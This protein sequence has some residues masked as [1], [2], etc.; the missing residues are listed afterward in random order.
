MNDYA[1]CLQTIDG[2]YQDTA[3]R[4]R[5]FYPEFRRSWDAL[6]KKAAHSGVTYF[7]AGSPAAIS[8]PC[9]YGGLD[10][11]FHLDQSKMA[12]WY[13]QEVKRRKRVVFAPKRFKRSFSGKLSFHESVCHYDPALPEAAL[14]EKDRNILAAAFPGLPP[15]LYVVYGN[16]WVDRAV[17]P[18]HRSSV[19]LFL[20][21]TPFVPAFLLSPFEICLYLFLMDYC[22]IKEDYKK[23]KDEDLKPLLHIFQPSPMLRIKGLL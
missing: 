3:I 20:I 6:L 16:K 1:A 4:D 9:T 2:L 18:F 8:V 19:A 11:V 17:N 23:V 7:D 14:E 15:E 22:I 21:Q 13:Y 10:F 5:S 12:D